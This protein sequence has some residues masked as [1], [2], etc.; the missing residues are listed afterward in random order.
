MFSLSCVWINGWVNNREAG[1]LRRYHAHYDV[2]VLFFPV[3]QP[4]EA[5]VSVVS[6]RKANGEAAH[7]AARC[8]D[9]RVLICAGSKN[10]H[11]LFRNRGR[12]YHG[13][14]AVIVRFPSISQWGPISSTD[15]EVWGNINH[16]NRSWTKFS[17]EHNKFF[18]IYFLNIFFMIPCGCYHL[19][20]LRK[21]L[22]QNDVIPTWFGVVITSCVHWG[23]ASAQTNN[24]DV[25][26]TLQVSQIT[27]PL[28]GNPPRTGEFPTQRDS[29]VVLSCLLLAR[30]NFWINSRVTGDLRR[31]DADVTSL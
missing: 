16:T 11:M 27:G 19:K 17:C 26:A 24:D 6:T 22:C 15:S 8:I 1:D 20:T 30:S 13:I 23:Y 5:A 29:N 3:P 31:H 10:V 12:G 28:W 25:K 7:L 21:T 18:K 9:G 4:L 14:S 2:I